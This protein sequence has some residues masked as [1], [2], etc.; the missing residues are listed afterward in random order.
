MGVSVELKEGQRWRKAGRPPAN[1]STVNYPKKKL[2]REKGIL[3]QRGVSL[4][5]ISG[6]EEKTVE[7]NVAN[8]ITNLYK[9]LPLHSPFR[10]PLLN[11]ATKGVS[12]SK[13][14][15]Y[16]Q[17]HRSTT[18]RSRNLQTNIFHSIKAPLDA[19]RA[20]LDPDLVSRI[21]RWMLFICLLKSGDKR[22]LIVY[23]PDPANPG[24]TMQE[25][26]ARHPQRLTNKAFYA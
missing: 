11:A 18:H 21:Q 23:L 26:R 17:V 5:N 22:A 14:A 15:E 7:E 10:V 3:L 13:A 24:A 20:R 8:N 2:K 9:T 19:T 1:K 25:I 6:N 4:E 16:F 12:V